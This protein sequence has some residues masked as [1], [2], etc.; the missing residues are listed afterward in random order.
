VVGVLTMVLGGRTIP[1]VAG[2]V[3]SNIDNEFRFFGAWYAIAGVFILRAV[4]RDE[5][6]S[7]LI[8]GVAATLFAA[9]SARLLGWAT[10]GRPTSFQLL[11][12]AIEYTLSVVLVVWHMSLGRER[13]RDRAG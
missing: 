5:V 8:R 7:W 4:R 9:A 12:G 2:A 3:P 6:T 11:L 10:V 1:G 13:R